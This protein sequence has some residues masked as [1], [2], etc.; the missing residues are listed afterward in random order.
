MPEGV[1]LHSFFWFWGGL[2][3]WLVWGFFSKEVARGKELLK[4]S[5][6]Q[7]FFNVCTNEGKI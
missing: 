6:L 2:E 1:S 3:W 7:I 4:P 5:F